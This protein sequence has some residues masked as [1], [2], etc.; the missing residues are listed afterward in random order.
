MK[1]LCLLLFLLIISKANYAQTDTLYI[2]F[3]AYWE[4]GD[5]YEFEATKIK[6]QWDGEILTKNDSITYNCILKVLEETD[7]SYLM[8]WKFDSP[9]LGEL[10]LPMK[11]MGSIK[12]FFE[13]EVIYKTNELGEFLEVINL[14]EIRS[15]TNNLIDSLIGDD[16]EKS[17]GALSANTVQQIKAMLT[18]D[19]MIQGLVLKEIQFIHMPFGYEYALNETIFYE[20]QLPNLFGGAPLRGDVELILLEADT[21]ERKAALVR[22]MRINEEDTKSFLTGLFGRLQID[23]IDLT[24]FIEKTTYQVKDDHSFEYIYNPGIPT[25]IK[26]NRETRLEAEDQKMRRQDILILRLKQ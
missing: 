20:E 3:I 1:K 13:T 25:L 10:G 18:S 23:D 4:T 15:K 5:I 24:E 17:D 2:P 26:T 12:G 19:Q 7:S 22:K 9:F 8:S 21:I 6:R 14:E 16:I 11:L